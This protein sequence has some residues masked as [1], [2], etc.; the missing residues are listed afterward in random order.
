MRNTRYWRWRKLILRRARACGPKTPPR[1]GAGP[2]E[3]KSTSN[4]VQGG[5]SIKTYRKS[6]PARGAFARACNPCYK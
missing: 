4:P 2:D 5:G 3:V 6:G 1:H